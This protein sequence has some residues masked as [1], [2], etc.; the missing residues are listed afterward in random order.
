LSLV[1]S[2]AFKQLIEALHQQFEVVIIDCPP[3]QV[4][5]DALMIGAGVTGVIYVIKADDTPIATARIGL[6][7]LK[8]AGAHTIGVILNQHNHRRAY[9]YYGE[10]YG[11][12]KYSY[13]G[14]GYSTKAGGTSA[15]TR[16]SS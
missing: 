14:Y 12:G 5:S 10:R 6:R 16:A 1:S 4:V 7:R 3:V 2:L 13:K 11:Y 9:K 8:E 15:S